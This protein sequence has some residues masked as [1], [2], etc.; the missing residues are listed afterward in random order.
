MTIN[1]VSRVVP[2]FQTIACSR[3]MHDWSAHTTDHRH[4][5]SML[6]SHIILNMRHQQS[7]QKLLFIRCHVHTRTILRVS[8]N[9]ISDRSIDRTVRH[10]QTAV[11][12]YIRGC[13]WNSIPTSIH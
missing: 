6:N 13:T 11:L 8:W 3:H 12:P 2:H 10:I 7:V 4:H 1:R 9:T 5:I